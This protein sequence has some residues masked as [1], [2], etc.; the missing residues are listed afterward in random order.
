MSTSFSLGSGIG[1]DCLTKGFPISERTRAVCVAIVRVVQENFEGD[2][3]KMRRTE[4]RVLLLNAFIDSVKVERTL[5]TDLG[6]YICCS[7]QLFHQNDW[8]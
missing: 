3:L 7:H 6:L 1:N 5:K 8:R 2:G 4:N